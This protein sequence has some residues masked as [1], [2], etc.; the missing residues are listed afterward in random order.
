MVYYRSTASWDVI[1]AV[2]MRIAWLKSFYTIRSINNA[3]PTPITTAETTRT[4]LVS[5]AVL[6]SQNRAGKTNK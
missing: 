6:R 1:N 4:T 3:I 2:L 5:H